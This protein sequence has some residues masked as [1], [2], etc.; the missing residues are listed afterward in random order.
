MTILKFFTNT[1]L[2]AT[3]VWVI[4]YMIGTVVL[5]CIHSHAGGFGSPPL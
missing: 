5:C 2:A 4:L 3:V 1:I